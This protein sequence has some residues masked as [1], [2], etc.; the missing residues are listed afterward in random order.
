MAKNIFYTLAIILVSLVY[1]WLLLSSNERVIDILEANA[2]DAAR[3]QQQV[4]V[5]N[6]K[7]TALEKQVDRTTESVVNEVDGIQ[8]KVLNLMILVESRNGNTVEETP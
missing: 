3:A 8:D 1:V 6:A 5:L 4:D 2:Q 7:V